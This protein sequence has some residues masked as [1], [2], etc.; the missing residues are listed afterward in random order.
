MCCW[1]MSDVYQICTRYSYCGVM[2]CVCSRCSV[3]VHVLTL[4]VFVEE[5]VLCLH[6]LLINTQSNRTKTTVKVSNEAMAQL[7]EYSL[8]MWEVLGSKPSWVWVFV[9]VDVGAIFFYLQ[10]MMQKIMFSKNELSGEICL[11]VHMLSLNFVAAA[12]SNY[13]EKLFLLKMGKGP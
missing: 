1:C 5:W 6:V 12:V 2:A 3:Y 8:T 10:K 11:M 13:W 9:V 7:V 4:D